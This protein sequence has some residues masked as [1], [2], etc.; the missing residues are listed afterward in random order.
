MRKHFFLIALLALSVASCKKDPV[1]NNNDN[2]S[3]NPPPP[4]PPATKLLQKMTE[5]TNGVSTVYNLV[6]NDA[7]QLTAVKTSDNSEEIDF[8][9]DGDGNVVKLENI[10]PNFHNI[11]TYRY[12]NGVPASGTFKSYERNNGAETLNEDDVI[13][14]D[15][16]NGKVTKISMDLTMQQQEADFVLTYDNNGN[17]TKIKTDG[18]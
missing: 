13:H 3:G 16:D 1:Q 14:Y 9:Y 17:V 2:G 7:K 6:Y 4:P 10:E 12:E 18:S 15:V 11:Y 8:T 5:T